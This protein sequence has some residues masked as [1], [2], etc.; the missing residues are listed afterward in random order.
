[1]DREKLQNKLYSFQGIVIATQVIEAGIDLDASLLVTELCPWSS[2]VQ[3]VGRCGRTNMDKN[4]EVYWLDWPS[5]SRPYSDQECKQTKQILENQIDVGIESLAKISVPAVS[6]PGRIL[7]VKQIQ[8]FFN[9]HPQ[10]QGTSYSVSD[11]VRDAKFYTAQVF[12]ADQPE[13]LKNIPHQRYLCPVPVTCFNDFIKSPAIQPK[14]WT[15]NEW[16]EQSKIEEGDV[17][18]LPYS[19]GGY[20]N[21]LGWTGDPRHKPESY[22]HELTAPKNYDFDPP[23]PYRLSLKIHAGDAAY[24]LEQYRPVLGQLGLTEEDISW[25]VKCARWHDWGK[26]HEIWQNYAKADDEILAKSDDYG[27]ARQMNGFRHELASAIAAAQQGEPFIVQYLIATHHGK[28]RENLCGLDGKF[29]LEILRGVPSGSSLPSVE[30]GN[31]YLESVTLDCSSVK[32]WSDQVDELLE[33]SNGRSWSQEPTFGPFRLWYL[34]TLIRN[35][36]VEA[37]Q[38]R[39]Q[40]AKNKDKNAKNN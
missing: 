34:E 16:Q 7:R 26:A 36:D 27:N 3:R 12:W 22:E 10:R 29:D 23:F 33:K 35:A 13:S 40:E 37:S 21:E 5:E 39:E 4:S 14:V 2:F 1:M 6:V 11:Y 25:L 18:C 8:Q 38:F 24:Y 32:D 20:S 9:T 17:V 19:A 28:V 31:E 30:L 15:N